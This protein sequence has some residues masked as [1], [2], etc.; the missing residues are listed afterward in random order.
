MIPLLSPSEMSLPRERGHIRVE[1]V[2]NSSRACR[3]ARALGCSGRRN[4]EVKPI[5]RVGL[6]SGL[7]THVREWTPS[8][9]HRYRRIG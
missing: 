2:G 3:C 6:S 7:R 4:V 8:P 5:R 9:S 1:T